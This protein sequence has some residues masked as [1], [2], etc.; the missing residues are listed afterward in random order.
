MVSRSEWP[1][2]VHLFLTH[3]QVILLVQELS[4]RTT[5]LVNIRMAI[6]HITW[7]KCNYTALL[8]KNWGAWYPLSNATK[9]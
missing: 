2:S 7:F 1:K 8:C 5:E 4:Q 9:K 6:E 3:S